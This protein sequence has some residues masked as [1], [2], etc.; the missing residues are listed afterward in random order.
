MITHTVTVTASNNL[1]SSKSW[2]EAAAMV[3]HD[4]ALN[5]LSIAPF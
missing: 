1:L 4:A 2:D 5:R 3:I